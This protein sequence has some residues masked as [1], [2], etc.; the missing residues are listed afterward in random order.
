MN[1][2]WR[3]NEYLLMDSR[4]IPLACG[5]LET[6]RSAQDWKVRILGNRISDVMEHEQLQL[7]PLSSGG[8]CLLGRVLGHQ[9]NKVTVRKLQKLDSDMRQNLRVSTHFKSLIY[10]VTGSWRGRRWIE[11]NDL[12]CGGVAF[13]CQSGL[14][15]GEVV[16]IVIPVTTEPVIVRCKVL[17]RRPS[18][19]Q[20][21]IMYATQ[22]INMCNDEEILIREAVFNI[23]VNTKPKHFS[24]MPQGE[25]PGE[26]QTDL[27]ERNT[28][29]TQ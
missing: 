23:E 9:Q 28:E 8:E 25:R 21:E 13:F 26:T 16:E 20:D 24:S 7:L 5:V 6:P 10:P 4:S 22:F 14:K 17:R 11:A 2:D 27:C 15:D 18:G 12:S 19:R 29:G 1:R 3:E